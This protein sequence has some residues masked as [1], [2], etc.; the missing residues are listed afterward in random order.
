MV[1]EDRGITLRSTKMSLLLSGGYLLAIASP[2][3]DQ[4]MVVV[5]VNYTYRKL[6]RVIGEA[7][8][9]D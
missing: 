1:C 9:E 5:V 3:C 4:A 6:L 8:L 2:T 7:F